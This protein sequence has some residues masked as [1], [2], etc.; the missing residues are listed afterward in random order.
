ECWY[1]I[2]ADPGAKIIFGHTAKTRE[3]FAQA[4]EDGKWSELLVEVPVKAGDFF[5]VPS[6]TVHAIGAGVMVLETQ[7]SSDTTY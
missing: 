1:V 4:I 2:S 3:D 5:Y 7:Q 6:G